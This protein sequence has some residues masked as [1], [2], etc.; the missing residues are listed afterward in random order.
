M[1]PGKCLLLALGFSVQ[2]GLIRML[3]RFLADLSA[4]QRRRDEWQRQ[5]A[6]GLTSKR[7]SEWKQSCRD[8]AGQVERRAKPNT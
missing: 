3:L 4:E 2:I 6:R 8:E 7:Y 5:L 1:S